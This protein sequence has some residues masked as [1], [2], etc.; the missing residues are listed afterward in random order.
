[1]DYEPGAGYKGH[2]KKRVTLLKHLRAIITAKKRADHLA[3]EVAKRPL[4]EPKGAKLTPAQAASIAD[5]Y[6]TLEIYDGT[7][8]AT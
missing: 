3:Q 1:M 7:P 4:F 8:V 2:P 6:K 5:M